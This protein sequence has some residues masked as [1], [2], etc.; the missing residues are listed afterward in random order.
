[1]EDK[2]FENYYG[3]FITEF[4]ILQNGKVVHELSQ[5][6]K[7]DNL[8]FTVRLGLLNPHL[9]EQFEKIHIDLNPGNLRANPLMPTIPLP[10]GRE[11][12]LPKN[13]IET[14]IYEAN[15]SLSQKEYPIESASFFMVY[16]YLL[17]ESLKDS[18]FIPTRIFRTMILRH[19]QG[20][21]H[22]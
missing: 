15:Y 6:N 13:D 22:A 16:V 21:T 17:Q 3:P 8:I 14:F 7:T 19:I 2:E 18:S 12:S 9:G 4:S 10:E 11:A 20:E 1:M 5:G